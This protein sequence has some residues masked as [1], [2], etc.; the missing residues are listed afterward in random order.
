[1]VFTPYDLGRG[2]LAPSRR[3]SAHEASCWSSAHGTALAAVGVVLVWAAFIPFWWDLDGAY[4]RTCHPQV[5]GAWASEL[6]GLSADWRELVLYDV[7]FTVLHFCTD[8]VVT[9]A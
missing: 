3:E 8:A 9:C 6:E 2:T 1:M 5:L 7:L 4:Y